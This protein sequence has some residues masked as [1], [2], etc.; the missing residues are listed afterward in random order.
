MLHCF[1]L[2]LRCCLGN[3]QDNHFIFSA[4]WKLMFQIPLHFQRSPCL[5]L[6]NTDFSHPLTTATLH[7][8]DQVILMSLLPFAYSI[9]G[10]YQAVIL[11]DIILGERIKV[12]E[13][14]KDRKAT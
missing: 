1:N 10:T 12:S 6:T 2:H 3:Y 5:L 8:L 14:R 4:G 7:D 13:M 9:M 11:I